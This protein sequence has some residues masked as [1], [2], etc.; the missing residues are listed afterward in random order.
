MN[1]RNPQVSVIPFARASK[2][3]KIQTRNYQ[4]ENYVLNSGGSRQ[5]DK[6][7]G[8]EGAVSKKMFVFKLRGWGA[9]FR[10][11]TAKTARSGLY[12]PASSNTKHEPMPLWLCHPYVIYLKAKAFIKKLTAPYKNCQE[13]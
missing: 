9:S 2:Q 11:A 1:K 6:D 5:S 10:S 13:L 8:G 3:F 7:G 4:K 12:S